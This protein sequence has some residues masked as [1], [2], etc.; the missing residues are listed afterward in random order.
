[1][2]TSEHLDPRVDNTLSR[3]DVR[4]AE[5]VDEIAEARAVETEVFLACD[6]GEMPRD[7]DPQSVFF[8]AHVDHESEPVGVLR[9][10]VG[11]PL[12]LPALKLPLYEEWAD[13]IAA[14]SPDR[15]V[16]WG[17]L[18]VPAHQQAAYGQALAKALFRAGW[19]FT[20]DS[21]SELTGMVMEPRRAR[22]M[23]RWYGFRFEQAGPVEWY[24]GGEVA[25][26]FSTSEELI[27]QL[28][29][30]NPALRDYIVGDYVID[31]REVPPVAMAAREAVAGRSP[32]T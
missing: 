8:T 1:M 7:L 20:A 4:V 25:A 9:M 12:A 10:I 18:A 23:E 19:R 27:S 15:L 21:R 5:T 28:A 32:S 14:I 6:Y 29:V 30:N 11:A 22:V 3:V 16:E 13:R 31:L 17:A 2:T 26:H 24:M